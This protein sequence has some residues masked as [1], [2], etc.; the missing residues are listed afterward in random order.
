MASN[1]IDDD[2]ILLFI[3]EIFKILISGYFIT[4]L[5]T[6]YLSLSSNLV[7]GNDN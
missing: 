3:S 5:Y 2:D 6:A 4:D 1:D 7:R